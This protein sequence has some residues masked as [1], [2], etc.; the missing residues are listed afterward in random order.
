M[1]LLKHKFETAWWK[2]TISLKRA[3]NN[4]WSL[5][6]FVLVLI[7]VGIGFYGYALITQ[8]WTTPF[9]GDYTQ[10]EIPLFYNSYDDWWT[11]FKTGKFVM[12]DESMYLGVDNIGSN[13]FYC[14]FNPFFMVT[15]LFP[16]DWIPQ[17]MA[18]ESILKVVVAGLL[19]RL[20]LKRFDVKEFTAR[21]FALAYAV[22][23]WVAF[24]FW[25][26]TFAE[27]AT[28]LPLLLLGIEIVLK[29]RKPWVLITALFLEAVTNYFFLFTICIFGVLYAL[30][31]YFQ[32][33]K[34]RTGKQNIVAIS[35]GI[36]SFALALGMAAFVIIPGYLTALESSR[37]DSSYLQSLQVLVNEGKWSE[38]F[39]K[40]FTGWNTSTSAVYYPL[41]SFFYPTMSC[42]Y[43]T[44]INTDGGNGWNIGSSLFVFIPTCL[45][46]FVSLFNSIR[47]KKFLHLI[48]IAFF[49]ICLFVPFFYYAFHGFTEIYG[50]W[51]IICVISIVTYC[52]INFDE[53][54]EMPKWF[55]ITSTILTLL[56]MTSAYIIVR[57]VVYN[58]S[59][60]ATYTDSMNYIFIYEIV[61]CLVESAVIF[62]TWKKEYLSKIMMG[63]FAL[64]AIVMGNIT[65]QCQG[66]ISYENST[67]GGY[68]NVMKE[69]QTINAIKNSDGSYYRMYSTRAYQGNENIQLREG[70][71]G[72]STFHSLYNYY[73]GD[74]NRMS[75][76]FKSENTWIGG[77]VEKR[78]NLDEFLGVKYYIT[79]KIDNRI[80][81]NK[82]TIFKYTEPNIP[83]GFEEVLNEDF[84]DEYRVFVNANH[85][86][87]GFSYDTIYYKGDVEDSVLN[88]F[89]SIIDNT[90]APIRNEEAYLKGAILNNADANEIRMA[91]PDL[92]YVVAPA[93]DAVQLSVNYNIYTC[94]RIFDPFNSTYYL[95][96][97]HIK[98]G[99][100]P[101]V[102]NSTVLEITAK[103]GAYLNIDDEETYFI[104]NYPLYRNSDKNYNAAIYLYGDDASAPLCSDNHTNPGFTNSYKR[105]RGFY[106]KEKV[107]RMVIVP[108]STTLVSK[109]ELYAES[110]STYMSRINEFKQYP[111]ENVTNDVNRYTFTT[112]FE[113]SRF[114]VLQLAY[115][116]GWSIKARKNNGETA[117]LS[118][119]N[120]QGGFVGFMSLN[121]QTTYDVS[122]TTKYINISLPVS[123][124]SFLL[125]GGTIAGGVVIENKRRKKYQIQK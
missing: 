23:G 3:I 44:F 61:L 114:I 97:G 88:D 117:S 20:Y 38:V 56:F 45:L 11:F 1:N 123:L 69:T 89:N 86:D 99:D 55:F 59:S 104:L 27:V 43:V 22:C 102:P 105:L 103:S 124:V 12:W 70:Y 6:Y 34:T 67:N 16:R 78:I 17:I 41:I 90:I 100:D 93:R 52:A 108:Y 40:V 107:K 13:S 75:H 57:T 92:N 106:G 19:M 26:N 5:F 63:F 42:R 15:L 121:G 33:F 72:V 74:F 98:T 62:I 125:F 81:Y 66:I 25:Y 110:Y 119:Y 50:R 54:F 8:W 7:V 58:P 84:S 85:I 83:F 48:P 73:T 51:Q 91:T 36:G 77:I 37:A 39:A 4:P 2:F 53:R 24:Y 96:K 94:D 113:Q 95:E 28:F 112:D 9:G 21:A 82:G 79:R 68:A 76:V 111:L 60:T 14:L 29:E 49:I 87:L 115:E 120:A 46:F 47:K 118:Y 80:S 31:R 65:Q 35:M 71:N 32:T 30:F 101:V 18:I 122:Y 116:K 109:P 64:E 10:Q